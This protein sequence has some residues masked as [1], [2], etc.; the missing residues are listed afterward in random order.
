MRPR[1]PAVDINGKRVARSLS[2]A[3]ETDLR[4]APSCLTTRTN[5]VSHAQVQERVGARSTANGR[6]AR[7]LQTDPG[8]Y[9]SD[10]SH[11]YLVRTCSHDLPI[12]LRIPGS[13]HRIEKG[14]AAFSLGRLSASPHPLHHCQRRS[15]FYT[16]FELLTVF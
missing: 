4:R 10:R 12:L 7:S 5:T 16:R 15:S 9:Q 6:K 2:E 3:N 14:P 1:V 11:G 13:G 8:E